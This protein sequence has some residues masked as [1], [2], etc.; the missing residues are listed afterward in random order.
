[1]VVLAGYLINSILLFGVLTLT[2]RFYIDTRLNDPGQ[3]PGGYV[4]VRISEAILKKIEQVVRF[5]DRQRLLTISILTGIMLF[6]LIK[7]LIIK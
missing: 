7:N 3:L 5:K 4:I 2:V 1:M 6:G